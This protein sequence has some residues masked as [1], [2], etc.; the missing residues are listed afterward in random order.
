VDLK[1]AH[2]TLN[3]E[4]MANIRVTLFG[5]RLEGHMV[6][7]VLGEAAIPRK[8]VRRFLPDHEITRDQ[9]RRLEKLYG[10]VDTLVEDSLTFLV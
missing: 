10:V 3:L 5:G 6:K 4:E 8:L 1:A 2:P 7:A 9:E